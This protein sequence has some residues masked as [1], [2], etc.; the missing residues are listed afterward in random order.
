VKRVG[1]QLRRVPL[2][3]RQAA[4]EAFDVVRREARRVQHRHALD[5][6]GD[7]GR[8][9]AGSPAALRVEG[10]RLHGSVADRERDSRQVAAGG[11]ACGAGV[12]AVGRRAVPGL[13][14]E[15]VL[16]KLAIHRH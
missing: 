1:G 16:E 11:A 12:G 3:R 7:R 6:L 15:V 10:D 2:R 9:R 13:V 4:Q 5:G 8:R 14:G